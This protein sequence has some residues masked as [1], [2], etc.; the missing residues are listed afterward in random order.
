MKFRSIFVFASGSPIALAQFVEKPI[1]LH[2]LISHLCQKSVG[3]TGAGLLLSFLWHSRVCPP[4]GKHPAAPA[5][6]AN[7]V[8]IASALAPPFFSLLKIVVRILAPLTFHTNFR[9]ILSMSI[10][11]LSGILLE[12]QWISVARTDM[13][14]SCEHSV[15][16]LH[17][18]L[19]SLHKHLRGRH[20][21]PHSFC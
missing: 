15:S 17:W 3:P 1:F 20:T 19:E 6:T 13:L 10:K 5:H 11:N 7:D 21:A 8:L 16:P 2:W 9:I 18:G 14:R 4:A 12:M